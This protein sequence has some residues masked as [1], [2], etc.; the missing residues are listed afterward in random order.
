MVME[1]FGWGAEASHGHGLGPA[2]A[3]LARDTV[4]TGVQLLPH[5]LQYRNQCESKITEIPTQN[6][7][8]GQSIEKRHPQSHRSVNTNLSTDRSSQTQE[9]I[10][11]ER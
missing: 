6:Q 2:L 10:K 8:I 7:K 4:K 9:S 3:F 11:K 1:V 5:I